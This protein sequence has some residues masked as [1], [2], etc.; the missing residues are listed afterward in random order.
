MPDT[1]R[2]LDITAR[3][4]DQFSAAFK[5][6][7]SVFKAVIR[8]S[9]LLPLKSLQLAFRALKALLTGFAVASIAAF[10][11]LRGGQTVGDIVAAAQAMGNLAEATQTST[12]KLSALSN[13]FLFK[14]IE[15]DDFRGVILDLQANISDALL[16]TASPQAQGFSQLGIT[17]EQLRTE[18][19]VTLLGRMADGLADINDESRQAATLFLLFPEDFQKLLP[20]LRDGREELERLVERATR[21]GGAIGAGLAQRAE[22]IT[23][24][25]LELRLAMQAIARIGV[26]EGLSELL[27][28]INLLA[29]SLVRNRDGLIDAVRVLI[30][31][32]AELLV[33]IAKVAIRISALVS[34]GI[35]PFL[36]KLLSLGNIRIELPT[37]SLPF[38]EVDL[39]DINLNIGD[40]IQRAIGNTPFGPVDVLDPDTNQVVQRDTRDLL[41]TV[42]RFAAGYVQ[43]RDLIGSDDDVGG[44]IQQ[45]AEQMRAAL[46][47]AAREFTNARRQQLLDANAGQPL[48]DDQL[49][50][51]GTS[52]V[53]SKAIGGAEID[54]VAN[55]LT[56]IQQLLGSAEFESPLGPF[57]EEAEMLERRL[58]PLQKGTDDW[59]TQF[60]NG[61]DVVLSSWTDLNGAIA[62]AGTTLTSQ[63]LGGVEDAFASIIL[64]TKSAKDAF[65]DLAKGI[66]EDIARL[67]PRL[68]IL[69]TLKSAAL[70]AE[71]GITA[72]VAKTLPIKTYARGGVADSPQI[73]IFGEAGA[74]AFVPLQGG[75]IP[76]KLSGNVGGQFVFAPSVQALDARSVQ[77]LF[78][79]Q[80]ETLMRIWMNETSTK[81]QARDALRS[82][83]R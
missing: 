71:G 74:E 7:G 56:D 61:A 3:L 34:Q 64:G 23:G 11:F 13:A 49:L 39:G 50:G 27:P 29:E 10:A 15:F 58:P 28:V 42:Q 67:I 75:N 25:F 30:R 16:D 55:S 31:T 51:L 68:L 12:E 8:G 2:N 69:Q 22:A 20:L 5:R 1:K 70:L 36:D 45:Q 81:S 63:A 35:D 37:I 73:A 41:E 14:G 46:E 32:M 17:L 77:R 40:Q 53:V 18:D 26:L 57:I 82:G 62:Q 60:A 43:A 80:K 66:L 38:G 19:Y 54:A 6:L 79:D 9:F 65:K 47:G 52:D 59:L 76:V 83:A 4:R 78:I 21:F 48:T 44:A 72:G 33:W 24:A